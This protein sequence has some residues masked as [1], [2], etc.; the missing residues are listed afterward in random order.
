M[1]NLALQR[2]S[3]P[4]SFVPLLFGVVGLVLVVQHF[5]AR[6]VVSFEVSVIEAA[7]GDMLFPCFYYDTGSG[8]SE[9][10]KVCF[11]YDRRSK[12]KFHSYRITLPTRSAIGSYASTRWTVQAL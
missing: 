6:T 10:E 2:P 9:T 8:F 7:P 5:R 1:N 12:S 11:D 3:G 4:F